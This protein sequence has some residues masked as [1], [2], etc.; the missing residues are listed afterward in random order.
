ML[1]FIAAQLGDDAKTFEDYAQR[2]MLGSELKARELSFTALGRDR[3]SI[4][5]IGDEYG[6][7]PRPPPGALAAPGDNRLG[8]VRSGWATWVRV[9]NSG[10]LAG[11]RESR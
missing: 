4:L 6:E 7:K 11:H 10:F 9:E 1:A 5:L 2:P 8:T 3:F